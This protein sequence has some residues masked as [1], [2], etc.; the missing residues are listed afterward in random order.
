MR[1]F[2]FQFIAALLVALPL[3]GVL[4][5]ETSAASSRVA[6]IKELKGT[7]KVKKS[8][9]SKE[10][11]AFT[12]MSLNEGDIL[13]VGTGGSTVLQFANG[14][15]EDDQMAVS[16]NTTLTFSKL[17][18]SKGTTTKVSMLKGSVWSNVKSIKNEEDQ[19]TLETPTAIMGVRGTNLYMTVDPITGDAKLVIVS[20]I[21]KITPK[22]EK[23]NSQDIY[24]FPNQQITID[25]REETDKFQDEIIPIDIGDIMENASPNVIEA[26]IKSKES[27]DKEN[28]E[29]IKKQREKL[30]SDRPEIIDEISGRYEGIKTLEDLNRITRNLDNLIGNIINNAIKENKVDKDELQKLIDKANETL[31]KKLDLDKIVPPELTDNE[32]KKQDLIKLL[33]KEKADRVKK[34]KEQE[35]LIRK[36]NELLKKL[37]EEKKKIEEAN[38]KAQEE[39]LK[40][41]KEEYERQL[42]EL[43]KK[44]FEEESKKREEELKEQTASPRPSVG[45]NSGSGGGEVIDMKPFGLYFSNPA[46][47]SWTK[48]EFTFNPSTLSYSF[49][50]TMSTSFALIKR[51]VISGKEVYKVEYLTGNET[52][53][54][55]E[56]ENYCS[57]YFDEYYSSGYVVPLSIGENSIKI[58]TANLQET[59]IPIASGET[60][61]PPTSTVYTITVNRSAAPEGLISW[62]AKVTDGNNEDHLFDWVVTGLDKYAYDLNV[63]SDSVVFPSM[64]FDLEFNSEIS[65][66]EMTYEDADH[67]SRTITWTTNDTTKTIENLPEGYIQLQL[68]LFSGASVIYS[69]NL[70]LI[71]GFAPI[72]EY[73]PL[74]ITDNVNNV[75]EYEPAYEGYQDQVIYVPEDAT[76]ITLANNEL[77]YMMIHSVSYS[78]TNYLPNSNGNIVI[79]LLPGNSLF[80]AYF[81]DVSGLEMEEFI[82]ISFEVVRIPRGI[83]TWSIDN[84]P[85]YLDVYWQK[86]NGLNRYYSKVYSDSIKF[87]IDTEEN[88]AAQIFKDNIE[89]PLSSAGAYEISGLEEG[90]NVFEMEITEDTETK[91][92]ELIVTYGDSGQ[93]ELMNISTIV[94]EKEVDGNTITVSSATYSTYL[95]LGTDNRFVTVLNGIAEVEPEGAVFPLDL[96]TGINTFSIIIKNPITLNDEEFTLNILCLEGTA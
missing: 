67:A 46:T 86:V 85:S 91:P 13:A 68:K 33:E 3:L 9:G 88:V 77:S 18:D 73:N 1:K 53:C 28:D 40:K 72:Y 51:N 34:E 76:S 41:A 16:S 21:G 69:M 32:K 35:D 71:N 57:V 78:D 24:I 14:T 61:E 25:D 64:D 70:W 62:N 84:N 94:G 26:I 42:D 50:T 60:P 44:R 49:D 23:K 38:K 12:K 83:A 95:S 2:T 8:G 37:V 81:G 93:A 45:Q 75:V 92:Y 87:Y 54:Y 39:A 19:F 65:K 20:G 80:S 5:K 74:I 22:N 89:V 15:S 90:V 58:Y 17:S 4:A 79:P 96:K 66:A 30:D 43:E 56:V 59:S 11:T 10:F 82:Y 7:A 47:Y 52:E 27:I 63:I 55:S 6:V 48:R 36:Q 31:T 29:F